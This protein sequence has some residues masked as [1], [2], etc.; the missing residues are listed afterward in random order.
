MNL[1][2]TWQPRD[3]LKTARNFRC[4]RNLRRIE[5]ISAACKCMMLP[6]KFRNLCRFA[7]YNGA[8]Y[9][10]FRTIIVAV[11]V[12]AIATLLVNK[13]LNAFPVVSRDQPR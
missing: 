3:T 8:E 13:F 2:R 6:P 7:N 1:A 5:G 9:E 10:S 11:T 4:G 12:A